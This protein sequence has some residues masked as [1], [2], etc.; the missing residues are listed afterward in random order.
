MPGGR[1]S[2]ASR[3]R[4][5]S[6]FASTIIGHS[7]RWW[8]CIGRAVGHRRDAI[9]RRVAWPRVARHERHL[10]PRRRPKL[11]AALQR[12]GVSAGELAQRMTASS[13]S[14]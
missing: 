2:P 5:A 7:S 12:D 1:T 13:E 3:V 4:A 6:S 10:V 8:C 14:S 11:A 9:A